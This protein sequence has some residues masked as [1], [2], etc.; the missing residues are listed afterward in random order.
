MLD[1]LGSNEMIIASLISLDDAVGVFARTVL[2]F[3]FAFAVLRLLGRRHLSHLT[4]LD[5]LLV[6]GL[7][8]AVGDVMI[9]GENT[10]HFLASAIAILAVGFSIKVLDELSSRYTEVSSFVT[11]TALLIIEDGRII[12]DA[13]SKED[14]GEAELMAL[15]REK[16]VHSIANVKRAY[17]EIDGEVSIIFHRKGQT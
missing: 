6:I 16:G 7:G 13:L 9:Y 14:L 11:G 17:I 4:Y 15:L 8:S 12:P 1:V 3:F 10:A 5:L 2:I